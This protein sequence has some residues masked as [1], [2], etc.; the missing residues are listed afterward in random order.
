[1]SRNAIAGNIPNLITLGRIFAVPLLVWLIIDGAM[2]AAFW[3]FVVAGVS[4]ALDGFIAKRFGFVTKLG[5]YLDPIADK[6]LLVSAYITLGQAGHASA[7]LVILV[8]FRDVLIIGGTLMFHTLGRP[9][10]MQPLFISKFNT[11]MQILLVSVLLGNLGVG[12]PDFDL[13]PMLTMFVGLTTLLS[14]LAYLGQWVF[15]VRVAPKWR[16]VGPERKV[17]ARD[18]IESSR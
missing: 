4:D 3:V 7:W 16:G 17:T 11:L 12:I 13:V 2:S 1:M 10:E 9:I 8:V 5:S 18:R 15:G 14:G 6:A